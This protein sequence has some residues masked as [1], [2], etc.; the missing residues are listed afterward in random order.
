MLTTKCKETKQENVF[1][2]TLGT[3]NIWCRAFK[4]RWG[5]GGLGKVEKMS[6]Q[7]G[8]KKCKNQH[9]FKLVNLVVLSIQLKIMG[10]KCK[11]QPKVEGLG[12]E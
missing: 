3:N 10:D 6:C 1:Q 7:G 8:A 11:K 5:G 9:L 12:K 4:I 2:Y